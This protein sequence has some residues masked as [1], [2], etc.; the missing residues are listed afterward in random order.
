MV[1]SCLSQSVE[2]YK[3]LMNSLPKDKLPRTFQDGK[4]M[5]VTEY[6]WISGFYPGSLFYLYQY[7][8]DTILSHEAIERLKLLEKL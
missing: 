1:D 3:F 4:L 6:A 8:G 7:S 5:T 2:Q